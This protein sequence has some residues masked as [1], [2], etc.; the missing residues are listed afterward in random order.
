MKNTLWAKKRG[1]GSDAEKVGWGQPVE[2]LV[3]YAT[4]FGLHPRGNYIK[5]FVG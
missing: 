5:A 3:Y 2:G 4:E 1:V